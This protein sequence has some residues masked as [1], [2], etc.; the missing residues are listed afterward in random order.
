MRVLSTTLNGATILQSKRGE[1]SELAGILFD[2]I[3]A[4]A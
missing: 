4:I 1:A 2:T 3:R